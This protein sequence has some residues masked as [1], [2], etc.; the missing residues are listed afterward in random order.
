MRIFCNQSS[1]H[2]DKHGG[3]LSNWDITGIALAFKLRDAGMLEWRERE[4]LI[5]R[6]RPYCKEFLAIQ[7]S[8]VAPY[9]GP[10][11]IHHKE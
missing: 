9:H 3:G 1:H 6:A 2:R 11:N 7:I 8:V 10:N 5:F 4:N